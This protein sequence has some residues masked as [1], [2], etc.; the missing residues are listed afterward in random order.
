MWNCDSSKIDYQK[1]VEG[2]RSNLTSGMFNMVMEKAKAG[3]GRF[4]GQG[5]A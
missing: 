5:S 1:K 2:F 3:F 4:G